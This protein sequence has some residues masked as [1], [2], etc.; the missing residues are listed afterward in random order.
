MGFCVVPFKIPVHGNQTFL[1]E[2]LRYLNRF[3]RSLKL[4]IDRLSVKWFCGK[5]LLVS[6]KNVFATQT[7]PVRF[8]DIIRPIPQ[9]IFRPCIPPP[10]PMKL[11]FFLF[12]HHYLPANF[13]DSFWECILNVRT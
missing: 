10:P 9:A 5:Y 12:I 11:V 6:A 3:D 13:E 2:G 1:D 8:S 7:Q 4:L